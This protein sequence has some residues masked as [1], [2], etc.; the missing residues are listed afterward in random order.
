MQSATA[1]L[2]QAGRTDD[3]HSTDNHTDSNHASCRKFFMQEQDGPDHKQGGRSSTCNGID[4]G[5]VMITVGIRKQDEE[6]CLEGHAENGKHPHGAR[7]QT[8]KYQYDECKDA[9]E[10][11][12]PTHGNIFFL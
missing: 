11:H 12:L 2:Y 7:R 5:K 1:I 6:N 4:Q 10:E 8:D 3:D 9:A